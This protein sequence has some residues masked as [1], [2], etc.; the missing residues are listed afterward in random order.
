[1]EEVEIDPKEIELHTTTAAGVASLK[2]KRNGSLDG[3]SGDEKL[4]S[5]EEFGWT[6]DAEDPLNIRHLAE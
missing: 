4:G 3:E 2:R 6:E 5:D 1:M